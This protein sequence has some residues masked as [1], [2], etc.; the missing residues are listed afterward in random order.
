VRCVGWGSDGSYSAACEEDAVKRAGMFAVLV[1]VS[2]ERSDAR[3]VCSGCTGGVLWA[4]V[5]PVVHS[6]T[7]ALC[8]AR[9]LGDCCSMMLCMHRLANLDAVS[10]EAAV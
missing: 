5:Y 4:W 3:R 2:S 9:Q 7:N 6:V 8:S 1:V 10:C